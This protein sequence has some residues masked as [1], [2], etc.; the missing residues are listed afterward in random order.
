MIFLGSGIWSDP[1]GYGYEKLVLRYGEYLLVTGVDEEAAPVQ[2]TRLQ[3]CTQPQDT[4][5]LGSHLHIFNTG[6]Q[7]LTGNAS[8]FI[9]LLDPGPDKDTVHKE[10]KVNYMY[11]L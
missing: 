9:K 3:V 2:P 7:I 10:E 6:F 4:Q 8:V 1:F 5:Q 11:N